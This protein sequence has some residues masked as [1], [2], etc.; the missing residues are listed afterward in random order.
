ME[1]K[2]TCSDFK[3]NVVEYLDRRLSPD[4]LAGAESHLQSCNACRGEVE[5]HRRAW[6]LVHRIESIEPSPGFGASVRRRVRRSRIAAVFGSCAAAAA[7]VAAVFLMRGS[8]PVAPAEKD[9][10]FTRLPP[11]DRALLEELARDRTWELADNM[12]LVR[13]FELLEQSTAEEDH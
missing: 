11:E 8:P 4:R 3:P 10:A 1:R 12:D 13:A 6:D 5:A 7:I 9:A 2:M